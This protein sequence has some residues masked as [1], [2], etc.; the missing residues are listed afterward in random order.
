MDCDVGKYSVFWQI[1]KFFIPTPEAMLPA[2]RCC[3]QAFGREAE[4]RVFVLKLDECF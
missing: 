2:E 3:R 4:F 1:T